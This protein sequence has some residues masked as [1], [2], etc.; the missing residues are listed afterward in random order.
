MSKT[1]I[2][3]LKKGQVMSEYAWLRC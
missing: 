3:R 2:A 1:I